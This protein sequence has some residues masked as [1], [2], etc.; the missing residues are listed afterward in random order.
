[1]YA[2]TGAIIGSGT[3]AAGGYWQSSF[4]ANVSGVYRIDLKYANA[5]SGA[6]PTSGTV[7]YY[8]AVGPQPPVIQSAPQAQAVVANSNLVFAVSAS[9]SPTLNFQWRRDGVNLAGATLASLVLSNAQ[10]AH[11]GVYSVLVSNSL[12]SLVSSGAQLTVHV[13]PS[14][15]VPPATQT[16]GA[17]QSP[18]FNVAAS[19]EPLSYQWPPR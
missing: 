10:P 17:G 3:F 14:I 4:W 1:M 11:N 2:P 13:A 6:V 5:T 12:G 19:G 15:I 16:A 9:G 8:L 7:S 18:V